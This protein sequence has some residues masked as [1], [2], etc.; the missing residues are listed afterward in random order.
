[1]EFAGGRLGMATV[2][3]GRFVDD[4]ALLYTNQSRPK[5]ATIQALLGRESAL[6]GKRGGLRPKPANLPL[7]LL[8]F[9]RASIQRS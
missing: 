7:K 4:E 3:G 2:V 8:V 9:E 6:C 1:M 5:I